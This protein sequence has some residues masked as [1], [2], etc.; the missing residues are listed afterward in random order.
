MHYGAFDQNWFKQIQYKVGEFHLN[1]QISGHFKG[2]GTV[3]GY[4]NL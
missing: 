1:A 3:I 4:Q 2:A